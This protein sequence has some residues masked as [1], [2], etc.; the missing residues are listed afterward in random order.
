M[1]LPSFDKRDKTIWYLQ[2]RFA[3]RGLYS[4]KVPEN[5]LNAFKLAKN[6]GC[7]IELDIRLTKDGKVIVLHDANLMRSTGIDCNVSETTWENI[8]NLRIFNSDEKLVAM[9]KESLQQVSGHNVFVGDIVSGDQFIMTKEQL[10]VIK[11]FFPD[12]LAG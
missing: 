8:R 6:E 7:G 3:H 9:A 5:S 11:E 4:N 12:A 2:N 10:A 1:I